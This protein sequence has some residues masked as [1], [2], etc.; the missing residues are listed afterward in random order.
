M[1]GHALRDLSTVRASGRSGRQRIGLHALEGAS[2]VKNRP[3]D[4]SKLVCKRDRQHVVVQALFRCLDPAFEPKALPTL[5]PNLDQ[6]DPGCLN[7]Q[8]AQIAIAALRYAA[9]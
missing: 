3:S 6:H 4:A 5:W 1:P 9:Q 2:L 7:E 8:C